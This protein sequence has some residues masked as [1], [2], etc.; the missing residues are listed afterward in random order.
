M[1]YK[2]NHVSQPTFKDQQERFKSLMERAASDWQGQ[3]AT[4]Q[5]K[6]ENITKLKKVQSLSQAIFSQVPADQVNKMMNLS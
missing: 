4:L 6:V 3:M 1:K 2:D 5:E